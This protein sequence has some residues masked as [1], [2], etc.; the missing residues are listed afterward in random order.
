MTATGLASGCLILPLFLGCTAGGEPLARPADVTVELDAYSGL[1]NPEWI[2]TPEEAGE[3]SDLLR[4][5]PEA[6]VPPPRTDRLGYRGF[7]ISNPGGEGGIPER[8]YIAAGGAVQIEGSAGGEVLKDAREVEVWLLELA[9]AERS[10]GSPA[11]SA[12]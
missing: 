12:G 11:N 7:R 2:L 3:L 9:R 6:A 8:L 10:R 5:L 4:E 1:P